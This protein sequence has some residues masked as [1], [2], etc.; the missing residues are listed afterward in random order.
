M[1]LVILTRQH[2][3]METVEI[4][5]WIGSGSRDF[6]VSFLIFGFGLVFQLS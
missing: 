5:D 3:S 1:A 6:L 4:S 2:D